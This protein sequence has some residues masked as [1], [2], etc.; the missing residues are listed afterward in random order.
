MAKPATIDKFREQLWDD[1][2][3][4]DCTPCE[5]QQLLRYRGIFTQ[6]LDNPAIS[7]KNLA[8]YLETEHGIK[9]LAQ[10]Y[11]DIAQ[12]DVLLGSVRSSEKAW[13]RYLVVEKLKEAID[14]AD[15]DGD[16]FNMISAID[17]LAKYSRLDKED[18]EAL[19]YDEIVPRPIEFVNDPSVLGLPKVEN[20]KAVIER[21]KRKYNI[22]ADV[23]YEEVKNERE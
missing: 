12:A 9:S 22:I 6:K 15:T 11:R 16:L 19:P 2:D 4:I 7:N 23:E 8:K 10:A 1:I 5:R 14:K 21:V 13:I 3:T 17:K 18:Q 20:P